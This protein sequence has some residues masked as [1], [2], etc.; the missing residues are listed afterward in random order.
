MRRAIM[1]FALTLALLLGGAAGVYAYVFAKADQ[2]TLTP[3]VLAGDEQAAHGLTVELY[4]QMAS[5]LYWDT[6]L[7]V[8]ATPETDFRFRLL[9]ESSG[10]RG[11]YQGLTIVNYQGISSSGLVRDDEDFF[12]YDKIFRDVADRTAPGEEH[13]EIVKLEDYLESYPLQVNVDLPGNTIRWKTAEVD[14]TQSMGD[15]NGPVS[16]A[17]SALF[18]I[19]IL[20]G[21]RMEVSVNKDAAG[22]IIGWGSN[23]VGDYAYSPSS[24]CTVTDSDCF[25]Y[26][27][28]RYEEGSYADFSATPG[29]YGLY[30]LPYST[31]GS[32]TTLSPDRLEL[33]YPM[34]EDESVIMLLTAQGGDRLLLVTERGG[35]Q[36]L[37]VLDAESATPMQILPLEADEA[38]PLLRLFDGGDFLALVCSDRNETAEGSVTVYTRTAGGYAREYQCDIPTADG[39]GNFV[40]YAAMD[41]RDG[42]LAMASTNVREPA[43]RSL[44]LCGCR[45]MVFDATGLIYHG[46]YA[47]SL[48]DFLSADDYSILRCHGSLN[49]EL[50][51]RW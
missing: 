26:L 2:V 20:P 18:P 44:R 27:Y 10:E 46:V 12:G 19:P 33:V 29:G 45:L 24:L 38:T 47:S 6:A 14:Y 36:T 9:R 37:T 17:L 8:G 32:V 15:E 39:G 23:S 48:D 31:D 41:Y 40:Y 49:N 4:N 7:T 11:A 35:A 28:N 13:T 16:A 1:I 43:E 51:V 21:Q 25:F 42:K 34:A 22:Q 50:R 3:Q 30:R 5:N